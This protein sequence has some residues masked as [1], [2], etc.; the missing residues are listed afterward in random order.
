M[1]EDL[2]NTKKKKHNETVSDG[3]KRKFNGT[4]VLYAFVTYALYHD[5]IIM[6]IVWTYLRYS[7]KYLARSQKNRTK[8]H[9]P[10]LLFHINILSFT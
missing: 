2:P 6:I 1:T 10:S 8:R 4:Y 9:V 3:T 7:S 5:D